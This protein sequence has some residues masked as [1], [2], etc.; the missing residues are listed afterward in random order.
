M[1]TKQRRHFRL[2]WLSWSERQIHNL[3]VASSSLARSIPFTFYDRPYV[4]AGF[5]AYSVPSCRRVDHV[6][7]RISGPF[8]CNSFRC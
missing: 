4:D 5:R 3:E 1:C 6:G 8:L 2:R 7:T